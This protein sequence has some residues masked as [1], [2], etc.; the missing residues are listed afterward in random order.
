M[1]QLLPWESVHSSFTSMSVS[2]SLPYREVE[3][4]W[5][6]GGELDEELELSCYRCI[7][8]SD[9]SCCQAH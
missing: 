6:R 5:L 8:L 2:E 7:W 4:G 3:L 9:W 1:T